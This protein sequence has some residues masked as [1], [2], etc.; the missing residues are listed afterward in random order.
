MD[1][2]VKK[3]QPFIGFAFLIVGLISTLQLDEKADF[4]AIC[5]AYILSFIGYLYVLKNLR[6]ARGPLF[7]VLI[8]ITWLVPF[9]AAPFLSND[10]FRFFWDGEMLHLGINPFDF[11][12]LQILEIRT[13]LSCYHLDLFAGMGD[14]SQG[15]YSCYPVLN[16][17]YFY[18]GT[19]FSNDL[20]INLFVFRLL[21]L[22]SFILIFRYGKKTLRLLKIS[23]NRIFILLLNP[24]FIIE[25]L[26]NLHFEAVMVSFLIL[27]MYSLMKNQSFQPALWMSLAV[28]IKLIPLILTPFLLRFLGWSKTTLFYSLLFGILILSSATMIDLD[29]YQNFLQSIELYFKQFEF[30]S[31]LLYPYLG[32]GQL[33]YG[34]N[35]TKYYAPN[36]AR[37]SFFIIL[38]LAFYGG[39]IDAKTLLQR[40]LY[41]SVVY[42]TLTSTIHPWY[43]ILPLSLL[44]FHYSFAIILITASTFLSYGLY[45]MGFYG[46]FNNII[47]S[48]NLGL[49]LVFVLEMCGLLKL[50]QL[51]FSDEER[52]LSGTGS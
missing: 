45:T 41:A 20:K 22:L 6:H 43:W 18:I 34:W 25:S 26:G 15:N 1:F 2:K 42:M 11:T 29:N 16:Q 47:V 39:E 32:Y 46:D 21:F 28:Q 19:L 9:F 40:M 44:C 12:P 5:L 14:L 49:L 23:E 51:S 31:L 35:M 50:P 38:S 7:H 30:N 48:I 36:L 10:F 17:V 37:W 24:L 13:N 27:F 4:L 33:M 8:G 52:S 3:S